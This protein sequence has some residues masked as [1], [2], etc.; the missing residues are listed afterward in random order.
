MNGTASVRAADLTAGMT[1]VQRVGHG[2]MSRVELRQV[3]DV[4]LAVRGTSHWVLVSARDEQ[5]PLRLE[6]P[7]YQRVDVV[8]ATMPR[9]R[10]D[11][12]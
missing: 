6:Y 4:D 11:P 3:L 1:I 8:A 5:S 12:R 9:R 10:R 7:A 2:V